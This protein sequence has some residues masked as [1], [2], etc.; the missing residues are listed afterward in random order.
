MYFGVISYISKFAFASDGIVICCLYAICGDWDG[1]ESTQIYV[2]TL[3]CKC[4][5]VVYNFGRENVE[6]G[7]GM[8]TAEFFFFSNLCVDKFSV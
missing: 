1:A 5:Y 4:I 3:C 2:F 7:G 6:G 8:Y